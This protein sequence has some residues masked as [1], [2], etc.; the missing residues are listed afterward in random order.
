MKKLNLSMIIEEKTPKNVSPES[1]P[2]K[3]IRNDKLNRSEL[4]PNDQNICRSEKMR[5]Y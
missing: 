4:K 3:Y 2:L 5:K 1:S